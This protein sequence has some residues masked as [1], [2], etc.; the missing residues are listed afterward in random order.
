MNDHAFG[1]EGA[2]ARDHL[3]SLQFIGDFNEDGH[4]DFLA[5]GD[6]ESYVLFGPAKIDDVRLAAEQSQIVVDHTAFG[7]PGSRFDDLNADG[8]PDLAFVRDTGTEWLVTIIFGGQVSG[9]QLGRSV[10]W[11]RDWDQDFVEQDLVG[12]A[13]AA[14]SANDSDWSPVQAAVLDG[15]RRTTDQNS[16]TPLDVDFGVP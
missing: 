3:S 14:N 16:S 2:D 4:D 8:T 1:L 9:F 15:W 5:R 7:V 10:P 6:S 12:S 13:L 11:P